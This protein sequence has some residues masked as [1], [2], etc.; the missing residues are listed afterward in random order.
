M[1]AASLVPFV[2]IAGLAAQ[3]TD[4]MRDYLDEVQARTGTPGVSAAVAVGGRV[5]FSAGAGFADLNHRVPATGT[6]VYNV[7]SVSKVIA[8]VGVMALVEAG[9]VELSAPIQRYV[10]AF[11]A[12]AHEVTVR[13]LMTHTSGIRHYRAGDF[14][15]GYENVR[16]Y[17]SIEASLERFAADALLFEPGT[18]WSYSSYASNLIGGVV[19]TASGVRFEAF[20][21]DRVFAPA[22]MVRTSFDVPERVVRDRA[23]SYLVAS[24][25]DAERLGVEAGQLIHVPYGDVSYKWA[26]GGMLSTA[27]DLVRMAAA[28][29]ARRLLEADTVQ[30]MY[31]APFLNL[32]RW[33]GR[34][35]TGQPLLF[36][37]ALFW[38]VGRDAKG[39]RVISHGGSVKGFKTQLLN[40]P[41]QDV[42][43]AV[44][45]NRGSF[46]PRVPARRLAQLALVEADAATAARR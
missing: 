13:H 34:P 11:P 32:Q 33:S 28:L 12:K 20:L 37:Q 15:N 23:R 45:G 44:L 40:Y 10:P 43:V 24:A 16:R 19:E 35:G 17:L 14:D 18:A 5:V 27:E 41:E 9:E 42:A 2:L 21:R 36:D 39:R 26:G 7:G 31:E 46:Q 30:R 8:A 22:G 3:S 6:T 29:N 25:T 38:R 4:A 1:H